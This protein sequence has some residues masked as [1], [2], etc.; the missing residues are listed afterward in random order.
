MQQSDADN[1]KGETP[2]RVTS[3]AQGQTQQQSRAAE[4]LVDTTLYVNPSAQLSV[5]SSLL[6][7]H[8]KSISSNSAMQ[9]KKMYFD[10]HK[11]SW[12]AVSLL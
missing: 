8:S 9:K 11:S 4:P 1:W 7:T 6:K 2:T 5:A 10:P 12:N 3:G